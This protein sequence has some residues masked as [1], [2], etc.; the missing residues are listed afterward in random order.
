HRQNRGNSDSSGDEKVLIC[1]VELEIVPWSPQG[2][3]VAFTHLL[4][5]VIRPASPVYF[6]QY[7]NAPIG[8]AGVVA[9]QRILA[10][11]TITQLD[12]DMRA[13]APRWKW[14]P[15]RRL[16]GERHNSV[17]LKTLRYH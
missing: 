5:H 1:V 8:L 10:Y 3:Q 12:I 7:R 16:Q 9:A 15:I 14:R 4:M 6:A 2:K 17:S 11:E 13:C